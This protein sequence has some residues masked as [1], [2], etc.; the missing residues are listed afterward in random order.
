MSDGPSFTQVKHLNFRSQG[1]FCEVPSF[2]QETLP[3][4]GDRAGNWQSD[5]TMLEDTGEKDLCLGAG[6]D[7]LP[8]L[9]KIR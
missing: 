1:W 9:R 3:E 2:Q 6:R 5:L 7:T 8:N 4:A